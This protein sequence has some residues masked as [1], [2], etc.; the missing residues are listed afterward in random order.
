MASFGSFSEN[1][2]Q[3][4]KSEYSNVGCSGCAKLLQRSESSIMHKAQRLG[5]RT[6]K[7]I[8]HAKARDVHKRN[9]LLNGFKDINTWKKAVWDRDNYTC[10]DCGLY[11]PTIIVAHHIIPKM[12]S[13]KQIHDVENGVTLC[14]NCHAKKHIILRNNSGRRLNDSQKGLILKFSSE[15]KTIQ[16]IEKLLLISTKTVHAYLKKIRECGH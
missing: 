8:S 9:K 1:E 11:E 7:I 5:L 6:D 15:G 13:S 12:D 2:L 4:L 3:V 16:E 14:P 10:K